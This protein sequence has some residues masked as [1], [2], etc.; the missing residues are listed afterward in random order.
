VVRVPSDA[1]F[2]IDVEALR[3]A[4]AAD[5]ARGLKPMAVVATVGTTSSAS[6]DPI[7]DVA[8]ACR[9]YGA[10][11]HVDAAYGGAFAVLPEGR[12]AM[13]GAASADSVV[14]NLHKWLFVPLDFS[15]L[16][17]RRPDVLRSVFALTPEYLR[18][19]A[20]AARNGGAPDG[21]GDVPDHGVIDYMDYGIQLGR[22]FRALKA[23]MAFRAFGRDGIESR[24]REHC[25]LAALLE[26]WISAEP[27]VVLAAPQRMGIVCFRFVPPGLPDE[28]CDALNERIVERVNAS[29]DAYLTHTRLA[30]R[31]C[32]RVGLGN[33]STTEQHLAHVWNRVR[34]VAADIGPRSS[35]GGPL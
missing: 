23:W 27:H 19:D 8:E 13:D 14:V 22:R 20:S 12:W 33:V 10:W 26:A 25:R 5:V 31:A 6:V 2:R 30:G 3:A 1:E 21:S 9:E 32:I 29:G 28:E 11:L 17:T 18:G 35:R 4:M 24:I 7:G 15:A 34:V 16:F